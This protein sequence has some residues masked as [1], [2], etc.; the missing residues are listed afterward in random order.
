VPQGYKMT[1]SL[2][3]DLVSLLLDLPLLES[4]NGESTKNL[5]KPSD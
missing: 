1:S 4:N 5:T 2:L 3:L